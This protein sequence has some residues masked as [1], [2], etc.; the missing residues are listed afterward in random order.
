VKT[1]TQFRALRLIIS[2]FELV[3]PAPL[4][5]RMT[6]YALPGASLAS[7]DSVRRAGLGGRP[8]RPWRLE[9]R[10]SIGLRRPASRSPWWWMASDGSGSR[11]EN[12]WR[13]DRCCSHRSGPRVPQGSATE[14]ARLQIQP[15]LYRPTEPL[16]VQD[17]GVPWSPQCFWIGPSCGSSCEV[18]LK[19]STMNA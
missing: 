5:R 13:T 8:S 3:P 7:R 1:L 12:P 15:W 6:L 19:H 9:P 17:V 10:H 2:A 18:Q 11:Y 4:T 14:R 16:D